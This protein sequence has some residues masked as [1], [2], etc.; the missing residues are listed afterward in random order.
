L[1]NIRAVGLGWERPAG[2]ISYSVRPPCG[3]A[4]N[5]TLAQETAISS[6]VF[7]VLYVIRQEEADR[8]A[9]YR[10]NQGT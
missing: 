3:L 1:D 10:P 4:L 6:G 7:T 5:L 2:Q 9:R 8:S